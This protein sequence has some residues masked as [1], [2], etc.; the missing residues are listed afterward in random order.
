M[1]QQKLVDNAMYMGIVNNSN[2][3]YYVLIYVVYTTTN[4]LEKNLKAQ[5]S[6][7]SQQKKQRK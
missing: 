6:L 5:E 3:T 2:M 7:A 1:Q 4:K